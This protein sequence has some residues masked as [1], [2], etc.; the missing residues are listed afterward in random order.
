MFYRNFLV[1]S[2]TVCLAACVT[3]GDVPRDNEGSPE[4]AAQINYE[5]GSQYLRQGRNKL[6]RERLER[7]TEQDPKLPGP[8]MALA[9]LYERTGETDRADSAYRKALKVAPNDANAQNS[10]AVFLCNRGEH[11]A[12]Q[13]YFQK[14]AN[15]QS[16]RSPAVAFNNAGVC[17]LEQPDLVA[18]E[19]FFRQA[20]KRDQ[21]FSDALLQM[22]SVSLRTGKHLQARAFIERYGS[23]TEMSAESLLLAVQI[24]KALGNR[25]ATRLYADRL[26]KEFPDSQQARNLAGVLNGG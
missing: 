2:A 16:N 13:K 18:A 6:A 10:Y 14:A 9:L 8:H 3:S 5:L 21:N 15:N 22:A 23:G 24:E 17:A 12:G 20:L 25:A 11:A 7:A 19:G 26:Q 1:L 4:E